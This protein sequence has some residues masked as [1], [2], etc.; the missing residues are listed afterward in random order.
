MGAAVQIQ[1]VGLVGS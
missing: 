1:G